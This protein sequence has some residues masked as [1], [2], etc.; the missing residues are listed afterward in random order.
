M[1]PRDEYRRNL[2]Q[3]LLTFSLHLPGELVFCHLRPGLQ[4]QAGDRTILARAS[5]RNPK[6]AI[7]SRS[8][9]SRILLVACL[10]SASEIFFQNPRTV[11][12]DPDQFDAACS[13]SMSRRVASESGC[14][15]T[16]PSPQRQDALSPL[17]QRLVRQALT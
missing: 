7:V 5:P 16:A 13:I 10:L 2:C 11:V 14:S 9:S 6:L 4:G 15:P 17:L 1:V 12:P 3:H 8:V